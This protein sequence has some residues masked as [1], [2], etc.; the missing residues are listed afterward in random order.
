MKKNIIG[1]K[2]ADGSFYPIL[3]REAPTKKKLQVTTASDNQT[4]VQI[5]L[6]CASDNS[7]ADAEYVDTLMIDG[8]VPHQKR[9]ATIDLILS[10]DAEENLHAE[11]IDAESGEKTQSTVSLITLDDDELNDYLPNFGISSTSDFSLDDDFGSLNDTFGTND[12]TNDDVGADPF[13]NDYGTDNYNP[14]ESASIANL[15]NFNN[16][17]S[18]KKNIIPII[19]LVCAVCCLAICLSL[20]FIVS[21]KSDAKDALVVENY[22][23][24]KY[25]TVTVVRQDA[26][27]VESVQAAL[28][29]EDGIVVI[30]A[31]VVVPAKPAPSPIPITG[32][33]Y[34]VKWGDTLWDIAETYYKNPWVYDTIARANN[35]KNP[36]F[37]L[38]GTWIELPPM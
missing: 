25:E 17:D 8:L 23:Q 38:S 21:K 30:D 6:F 32:A 36:D 35:I 14:R 11:L 4:T 31:P 10:L 18:S 13:A 3:T 26:G 37:I 29:K 34:Q 5:N 15:F 28:S 2:Q 24:V 1:L 19:C 27:T 20:Y 22:P 9:G 7:F 16:E 12:F 33:R